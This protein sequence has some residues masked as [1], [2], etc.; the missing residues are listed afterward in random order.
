MPVNLSIKSL[1][2]DFYIDFDLAS[3]ARHFCLVFNLEG[4]LLLHTCFELVFVFVS[5]IINVNLSSANY[6][7]KLSVFRPYQFHSLITYSTIS[8]SRHK[9]ICLIR[10]RFKIFLET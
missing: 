6:H 2:L 5:F 1:D 10:L 7:L 9:Q 8:L 4:P 3:F